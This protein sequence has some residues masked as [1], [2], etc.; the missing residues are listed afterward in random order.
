[1]SPTDSL[2]LDEQSQLNSLTSFSQKNNSEAARKDEH[3][4]GNKLSN[5]RT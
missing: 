2:S 4:F 1:M 3:G 5:Q